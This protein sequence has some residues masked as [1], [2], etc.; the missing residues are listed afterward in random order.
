MPTCFLRIGPGLLVA[1]LLLSRSLA[2]QS[3]FP[4]AWAGRW[5]GTL[6]TTAPPERERNRVPLT[7]EIRPDSAPGR[8]IWRTV[9]NADTVRGLRDYRLLVVDAAAGRYQTDEGN[10]I[11]LEDTWVAGA[12]VS[13][14]RVGPQVLESRYAMVGDTLVHDI[15][16]WHPD[17]TTTTT[18]RGPNGEGGL[19]VQSHRVLGRQ[20]ATFVRVAGPAAP[21]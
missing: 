7:L 16:W 4:D 12:L 17:P 15:T 5:A 20:R 8:W 9:F 3:R 19:P 2:A 13:V 10:G 6:V 21:R 18:G 11:V 1:A 14:F